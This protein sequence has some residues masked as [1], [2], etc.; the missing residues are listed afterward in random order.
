[1]QSIQ[2]A[3]LEGEGAVTQKNVAQKI[4]EENFLCMCIFFKDITLT[5]SCKE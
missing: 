2:Y 3:R 1:M 5:Q 4:Y